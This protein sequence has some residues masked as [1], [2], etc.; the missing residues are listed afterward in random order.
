MSQL[1]QNQLNRLLPLVFFLVF[2]IAANSQINLTTTLVSQ[3]PSCQNDGSA[4]ISISG[5]AAPYSVYWT[6]YASNSPDPASEDTVATGLSA[7][8]LPP[9]FYFLRI[10]DSSQP[11]PNLGYFTVWIQGPFNLNSLVTQATCANA[12]GKVVVTVVDTSADAT[13]PYSFEW[14]NGEN[15]LNLTEGLDSIVN[16]IAGIYT[17][18]VTDGNG[19]FVEG[20]GSQGTISQEGF[21]VN[22]NSPITATATATPSNCFDGTATV[23]AANG[24]A[25]Y[26][27][28][29]NT[30]PAQ[31]GATATGL[32]PAFY[33]CTITDAVGC[34]RAQWINVPAGPNYLQ[35]TSTITNAVCSNSNGGVNLTV[36]GG[37]SPY[38]YIWSNGATT[39]DVTGLSPG[40]YSVVITDA[41][42][43][44]LTSNKYIQNTSP[45]E[46][47]ITGTAPSCGVA[48]GAVQAQVTGGTA[49]YTFT[50]NNTES[51]DNIQNL[52]IGY[53]N[54]QVQDAAGCFGFDY[55]FL[56]EPVACDVFITGKIFNDLNGNCVQDG[57]EAGLPNVLV[58]AAPGYH[59]G[60][61]DENGNYS[62]QADAGNYNLTVYTPDNWNQICPSNPAEIAV[63]ASMPGSTYNGNNFYL[64]PD[65][66][67]NDVSVYV[68]SGPA[69]PGF[70][71]TWYVYVTNNGTT[72]VG[73]T[74]TFT[75]D[76][77][78]TFTGASPAVNSY[79]A[80]TQT[81]TWNVSPIAP[82]SSRLYYL[83][84]LMPVSAVL[85]D[86]VRASA[87]ASLTGADA[88]P[89]DNTDNYARLISG[90]YDPND[91]A[92]TPKG[93]GNEGRITPQDTTLSYL[94]RFQNTGT[95][96][97]FTVVIR[98]TLDEDLDV[99]TF[100]FDGASHPM[101]YTITGAG[102]VTFTFNNILLPDSFVNEPL[103]H[104]FVRYFIDRKLDIPLGTQIANTA[105]IY[106]DFN[107]P[108][109]TNTTLN[110]LWD[111][112]VGIKNEAEFSMNIFPNPT[113]DISVL[114]FSAPEP[115]LSYSITDLSGREV[116]FSS[117]VGNSNQ[118]QLNRNEFN[119]SEGIYMVRLKT[120][121]WSKTNRWIVT[122]K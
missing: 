14:S 89:A 106:F 43:C 90:S 19:C 63:S 66:V 31:F 2:S 20:V 7:S 86:S 12:D 23:I 103:S 69:R 88:T 52:P 95:D 73:P 22:S 29:W 114:T 13:G 61:S 94:I 112:T 27:Y 25:P 6:Q 1:L 75:H 60:Y 93:T 65:S 48:N 71:L 107:L 111:E 54:V 55:Y 79:N 38:T 40:S 9:G 62:I 58:N 24:T 47:N 115:L 120:K 37:V 119:L 116:Y 41:Q 53:Y 84:S 26:T 99:T 83:Y 77:L 82:H 57:G 92:V 16:I 96:T 85:G 105:F 5:G 68:G 36:T 15:H 97:A 121:S 104:G 42:G 76:A 91:K 34:T 3:T 87:T 32:S 21:Y 101:T 72:S 100:R 98:D 35:A 122:G 33:I 74:L 49:P 56:D 11:N 46:V 117:Q 4:T 45:V 78:V 70:P 51:T 102:V 81:A 113:R 10:R 118:I 39:Q 44:S 50:W 30:I 28:L 64:E 17:V 108:I 80:G 18:T 67:F 109:V 110:T 59:Y 8:G